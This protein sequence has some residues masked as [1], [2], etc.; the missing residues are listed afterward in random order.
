VTNLTLSSSTSCL[1][2]FRLAEMSRAYRLFVL[3]QTISKK[4]PLNQEKHIF[5]RLL[6]ED[7]PFEASLKKK[8]N[9]PQTQGVFGIGFLHTAPA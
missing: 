8:K 5:Q 3:S 7:N 6:L 2:L 9:L 1:A 4:I